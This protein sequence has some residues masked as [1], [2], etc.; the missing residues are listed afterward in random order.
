M[1][2]P[3]G[4]A[5]DGADLYPPLRAQDPARAAYEY[6]EGD[7]AERYDE[8]A[9]EEFGVGYEWDGDDDDFEPVVYGD[10]WYDDGYDEGF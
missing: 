10:E 9:D 1:S 7:D 6:Y 8:W 5:K 4:R 2:S 3:K